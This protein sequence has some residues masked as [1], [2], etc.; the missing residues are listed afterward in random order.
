MSKPLTRQIQVA[1]ADVRLGAGL[2]LSEASLE[3]VLSPKANRVADN[4]THWSN[5]SDSELSDLHWSFGFLDVD[6]WKFFLPAFLTFFLRAR[7]VSEEPDIHSIISSF[8]SGGAIDRY[9]RLTPEQL[10]A[11]RTFLGLLDGHDIYHRAATRAR[12]AIMEYVRKGRENPKGT[13]FNSGD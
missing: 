5:V 2:T 8:S 10:E 13:Q 12:K 6:G 4:T 1:F 11:V 3:G 7:E 9:S